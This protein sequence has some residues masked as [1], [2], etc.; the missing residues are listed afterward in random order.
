MFEG[1]GSA[2]TKM[3]A[4]AWGHFLDLSLLVEACEPAAP[5]Y[6][7]TNLKLSWQR[8]SPATSV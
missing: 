3:D 8:H 5:A 6:S 4:D 1:L 2:G 7:S